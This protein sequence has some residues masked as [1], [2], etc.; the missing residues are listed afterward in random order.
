MKAMHSQVW[1]PS[2]IPVLPRREPSVGFGQIQAHQGAF[3][4]FPA[5]GG[6]A[7]DEDRHGKRCGWILRE[8]AHRF[9]L[10]SEIPKEVTEACPFVMKTVPD[11]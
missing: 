6:V 2:L 8:D 3:E 10:F 4:E 7:F 9:S 11:C 1:L 5:L